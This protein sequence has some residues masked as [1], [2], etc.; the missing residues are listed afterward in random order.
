MNAK[1]YSHT[2]TKLAKYAP[3]I[4][5]NNRNLQGICKAGSDVCFGCG[6]LGYRV[7]ECPVVSHRGKDLCQQGQSNV[8]SAPE[9]RPTKQGAT[10]TATNAMAS[11]DEHHQNVAVEKPSKIERVEKSTKKAGKS[12][13]VMP[14][15]VRIYMTDNDATDSSSDEEEMLH[16]DNSQRPKK[17][18]IREIMIENGRTRVISKKKSKEKKLLQVN[19]KKYRGVR[20]RKWGRWAA[21]IRDKRNNTRRWLGTFDTAEEAAVAYDEAAIEINGANALT[22]ILEPPLKKINP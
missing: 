22:N 14:R 11:N 12:S 1:E 7:R 20:Q 6:K 2:L 8:S 21:E 5:A 17:L 4:V 10:S 19:M 13:V 3:S 15:V 9:S 16:G 18:W